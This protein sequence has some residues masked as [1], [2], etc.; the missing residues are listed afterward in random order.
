MKRGVVK[1]QFILLVLVLLSGCASSGPPLP[2][3]LEVPSPVTD[4]RALRKGDKVYLAWTEQTKTTDHQAIRHSGPTLICRSRENAMKEC[5]TAV[6]ELPPA[7]VTQKTSAKKQAPPPK[8]TATYSDNLPVV[9]GVR[10]ED[11][12]TYAVE[13]LNDRKRGAGLSNRVQVPLLPA[14]PPPS[15]FQA[16]MTAQGT[17]IT[18]TC[19]SILQQLANVEYRLRVYRRGLGN[20]NDDKIA[21]PDIADCAGSPLFDTS[22]EWEKSYDYR[23]AVVTAVSAPGKPAIE[24]EGD[25]TDRVRVFAHDVFPPVV[26]SGLQAVFSG[27]GQQPFVDLIWS[28]DTDADLAGY[29]VYRREE[30]GQAAKLNSELV[31]TPAY[32]DDKVQSGKKH[33]YSVSAV[34]VRSNESAKSGETSEMV[35]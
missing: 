19:P 11:E 24:I 30:G 27:P 7:A 12:I 31:K 29:N 6:G 21:E 9:P 3:S 33:F 8:T 32:R 15:G 17:K 28:P 1:S 4:L 23:A 34:D 16:E 20:Q 35:P 13:V 18:W 10:P 22:F 2:P 25:D 26:P 5:G 14:I